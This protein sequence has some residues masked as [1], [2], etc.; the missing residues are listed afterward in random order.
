MKSRLIVNPSSGSSSAADVLPEI[1]SRLRQLVGSLDIVMTAGP[2]DAAR[3]AEQAAREGY[4]RLFVGG[5]DGTLNE[6][7]NG[8]AAVP[9]A[10][11][12]IALGVL[13]LGTGNDFAAALG[14]PEDVEAALEVIAL[15]R[16]VRVDVGW[17]NDRAFVNVSAGGFIA[18]VSEATD[19]RL[20]T[21]SGKL[22]YLIG[23][24]RVLLDFDPCHVR[25]RLTVGTEPVERES[26]IQMY[27]VCNSRLVGGG[28]L[29]AP[30]A[31]I[32]DG[33]LDVCLVE[34][35]PTVEFVTL[36]TR[37]ARG[38]HVDDPRVLYFQ[39]RGVDLE[40]DR[41]LKVNTDG[42]VLET[43]HCEYRVQP[44]AAR[45]LAGSTPFSVAR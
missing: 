11:D 19:T 32:D 2:G 17:L 7:L 35:M 38:E 26:R 9:G 18:E 27:A 14:V 6:A 21:I 5:G 3:A 15:G 12:R 29:I 10:M 31:L 22:A 36:L 16:E 28:K 13:P 42:E 25:L 45:F 37:V 8:L 30:H 4:D 33:L 23:G 24:A 39:A 1:N 20:K 43:T 40:F 41:A 44:R 34:A